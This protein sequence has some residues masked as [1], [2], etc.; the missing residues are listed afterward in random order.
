METF[1][2]P[3]AVHFGFNTC[4]EDVRVAD[5][6]KSAT[7]R[8]PNRHYA[9]GVVYS[10]T[11]LNGMAEFEITISSYGS[12]SG[13][14]GNVK[15]GVARFKAGSDI[16]VPRYSPEAPDHCVWSGSKL[17]NRLNQNGERER[18]YG[19]ID[20]DTLREGDRIGLRLSRDGD[21][22]FFVNGQSQGLA[23]QGIYEKGYDVYAVVDIYGSCTA[24]TI[25]RAGTV[26]MAVAQGLTSIML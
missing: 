17:Y 20:L 6:G 16:K 22:M 1:I 10:A 15:L 21:L 2:L 26:L 24:T 4:S 3:E 23:A 13:W 5:N 11:P 12:R 14:S 8:D 19:K 7:K 18:G 25:T 9:Y